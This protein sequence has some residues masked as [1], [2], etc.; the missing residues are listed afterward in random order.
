MWVC[1]QPVFYALRPL[2]TNPKKPITLEF[3]NSA[4]QITFDLLVVY[5]LGEA[6]IK[7]EKFIS[8]K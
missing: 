4:I 2:F 6:K 5:F 3:V 8:I 7:R 1:L